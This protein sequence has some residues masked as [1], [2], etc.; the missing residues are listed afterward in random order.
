MATTSDIALGSGDEGRLKD[1]SGNC[2]GVGGFEYG[3]FRPRGPSGDDCIEVFAVVD[4]EVP[5]G[6]TAG[7]GVTVNGTEVTVF[8][9]GEDW[10]NSVGDCQHLRGS[11]LAMTAD[12]VELGS[13]LGR[14][15]T[16]E[17][18]AS[19][20]HRRHTMRFEAA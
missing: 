15:T 16:V 1:D 18:V 11:P 7:A 9:L 4:V 17:W 2:S 20:L 3:R 8:C 5:V 10:A 14:D 12:V 13:M 6:V 19:T